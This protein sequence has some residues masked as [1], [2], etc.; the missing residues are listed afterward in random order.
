MDDFDFKNVFVGEESITNVKGHIGEDLSRLDGLT[1]DEV[2]YPAVISLEDQLANAKLLFAKY[3][4]HI[5]GLMVEARGLVVND[6]ITVKRATNMVAT[7]TKLVK[8]LADEKQRIISAQSS[9]VSSVHGLVLPSTK[10]L[11]NVKKEINDKIG[12]YEYLEILKRRKEAKRLADETTKKQAE[13]DR[14]ADDAKV[15][16]VELPK[17]VVP[18][19]REPVRSEAGSTSTKMVWTF[20]IEDWSKVERKHLEQIAKIAVETKPKDSEHHLVI[21]KVFKPMVVAGI[22]IIPGVRVY[23]KPVVSVRAA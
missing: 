20:E 16:R 1:P 14:M 15:E 8:K 7:V 13:F 2:P 23:E 12:N 22:R 9:F 6:D 3:E 10:Q 17:M 5:E 4:K 18:V 21:N 19:K 11:T